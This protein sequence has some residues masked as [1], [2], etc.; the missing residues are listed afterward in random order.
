MSQDVV[1]VLRRALPGPWLDRVYEVGGVVRDSLLGVEAA[2]GDLDLS[3]DGEAAEVARQLKR[4]GILEWGPVT[5]DRFGTVAVGVAGARVELVTMRAESYRERN[6]K[7]EVRAG[8]IEEDAARRDFTVNALYRRL[9]DGMVLD[10]VGCGRADLEARVLRTPG[11]AGAAFRE[12]PLRLLRMVRFR[13]QLGFSVDEAVREAAIRERGALEWISAERVREELDKM[14]G[15]DAAAGCWGELMEVGLLGTWL[16]E[17]EA[18][19]GV[20]QNEFHVADVWGHTLM[21][22][23]AARGMDRLTK[24]AVLLHDVG[25]PVTRTVEESGRV[26]FL[27]HEEVGEGMTR[28]IM[29]RLRF[30]AEETDA[31]ALLVRHHMRLHTDGAPTAAAL[32]RFWRD[33]GA[34]WDRQLQVMA[35]DQA[36]H[37]PG[38]PMRDLNLIRERIRALMSTESVP[39]SPLDGHDLMREFGIP[40]GR[41][42]GAWKEWL[43]EK[44]I[45]GELASGDAEGAR[46]LV[47]AAQATGDGPTA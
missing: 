7:P 12:D 15:L 18:M 38:V 23:D 36:A 4:A 22:L 43:R 35:A 44:V 1:E 25:K 29:R 6:R 37:K 26:R 20:G 41:T 24:W 39:E 9:S 31:V 28:T 47:R 8:T 21:A 33:T 16:P 13:F 10:P 2:G 3:V 30:S 11:D 32:R 42:V 14:M 40:G 46:A 19:V 27:G 45:S 5:Y 17:L 34:Q